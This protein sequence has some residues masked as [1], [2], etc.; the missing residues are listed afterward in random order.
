MCCYFCLLYITPGYFSNFFPF[1][2]VMMP[3]E[4]TRADEVD[5]QRE[6]VE[7]STVMIGSVPSFSNQERNQ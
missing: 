3:Q 7:E 5:L 4:S 6:Q 1:S 2:Q